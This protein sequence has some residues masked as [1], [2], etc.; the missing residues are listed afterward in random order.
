MELPMPIPQSSP[1]RPHIDHGPPP[2][3]PSGVTPPVTISNRERVD[4]TEPTTTRRPPFDLPHEPGPGPW[5]SGINYR[6]LVTPD[7]WRITGVPINPTQWIWTVTND[8]RQETHTHL[9]W[10]Y[11]LRC[12]NNASVG[13]PGLRAQD[14]A[15]YNDPELWE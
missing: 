9:R 15:I 12:A 5:S 7:R 4:F 11:A 3:S 10:A 8:A 6:D 2:N 14:N 1:R 13:C